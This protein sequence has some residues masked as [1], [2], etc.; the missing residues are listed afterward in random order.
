MKAPKKN[1]LEW[2]CFA[3]GFVLVASVLG[4]LTRHA[5]T[6][7]DAPPRIEF[8]L[9]ETQEDGAQFRVPVSVHNHGDQTAESVQVEVVLK[10]AGKEERAEFIIA[11]VP[12]HGRREGYVTFQ[13]D[14]RRAESVVARALGYQTP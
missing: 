12:K 3:L 1:W 4:Y 14:P 2:C 6:S 11:Q 9:G 13:A 8:E 10:G 5:A 7:G